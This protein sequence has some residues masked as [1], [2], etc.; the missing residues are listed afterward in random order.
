MIITRENYDKTYAFNASSN[1]R[2]S[3]GFHAPSQV[4]D[5]LFIAVLIP[6]KGLMLTTWWKNYKPLIVRLKFKKLL[7][8]EKLSPQTH[9][10]QQNNTI[11]R[12]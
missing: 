10:N 8:E 4:G 3:D 7:V 9:Q 1:E 11:S 5:I 2:L 12:Y 6:P